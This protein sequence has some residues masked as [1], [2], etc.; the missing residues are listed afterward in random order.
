MQARR[1]CAPGVARAAW[2]LRIPD[3]VNKS[4]RSGI[5]WKVEPERVIAPYAKRDGLRAEFSSNTS[6]AEARMN[7]GGPPPKA[8]YS[9]ATDSA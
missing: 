4:S 1:R 3:G 6:L 2:G 9:L 5:F 8:K 7:L